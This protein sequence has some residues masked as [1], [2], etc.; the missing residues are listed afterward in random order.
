MTGRYGTAEPPDAMRRF[1]ALLAPQGQQILTELAQ[2]A[3]PATSL[4]LGTSLRARY[5]VDLV[6]DALAQHELRLRARAK[7]SRAMSMFFTR[8]GL[9]QASAEVIARHRASRYTGFELV[10]DLCC[11]IGGDLVA[12]ASGAGVLAVDSDALHLRMARPG[13]MSIARTMR[14]GSTPAGALLGKLNGN[15][16]SCGG[17]SC[18]SGPRT[19]RSAAA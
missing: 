7:F 12:L 1:A 4:R 18:R 16:A 2:Q 3:D 17:A 19:S 13:V 5:P 11:G 14:R 15:C 6:V 10:A 9:E 8:P